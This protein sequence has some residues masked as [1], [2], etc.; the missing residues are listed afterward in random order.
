MTRR[1]AVGVGLCWALLAGAL[2]WRAPA[3]TGPQAN[4][5]LTLGGGVVN[6]GNLWAIPR[7]PFCPVFSGGSCAGEDT[8]RLARDMGSSITIAFAVS[9]FPGPTLGFQAEVAYLGLP[10]EDACTVLDAAPT[11]AGAQLCGDIAGRSQS[12]GAISFFAGA[13][14]RA[15]PR[16]LVSP[17]VRAGVG[18][19]T[20]DH[21]TIDMAGTDSSL[22]TYQVLLDNNPRRLAPSVQLG[23]GLTVRVG[24]GYQFRVEARD[25]MAAF[26]RV[27]GPTDAS[28]V[29]PTDTRLYH[30]FALSMGLDVVLEQK[31]GRRY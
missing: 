2:P 8:L 10:L 14:L 3:Q 6:G 24:Q 4:L 26:E 22:N 20:F 28:L 21:S 16:R 31:R 25:V 27:T 11:T 1:P 30:H 5:L 18:L 15:T 12:T 23:A 29:P 9:Y 7:Q 19:V 17:Y 13:I